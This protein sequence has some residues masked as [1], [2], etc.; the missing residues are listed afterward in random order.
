VLPS[1]TPRDPVVPPPG[2][3][4]HPARWRMLLLLACAELLG[5]AL[6]FSG[7][8]VAPQY[9]ALWGLSASE[10]GWLTTVV[11]LGFVGGTAASALLNLADVVPARRLF[12]LSALAGRD[13]ERARPHG[14]R[15][16]GGTG[17]ALRDGRLSRRRVSA[18]DEDGRDLVP[19]PAGAGRRDD[20]RGRSPWARRC[21]TSCTPSQAW[22]SHR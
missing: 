15:A 21:R 8:A 19:R 22:G 6:W 14:R 10:A 1:A 13:G 2:A 18:G 20:R 7:S 3:D 5:M 11:S 9:R 16:A 17:L 12:A 4:T